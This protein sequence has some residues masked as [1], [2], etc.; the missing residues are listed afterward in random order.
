MAVS[1]PAPEPRRAGGSSS[2]KWRRGNRKVINGY[3]GEARAAL[4]AAA[5][6][7]D[8]GGDDSAAAAALGLVGAV[9]EM[10]PRMEA[11]LEL[12]ARA[13]LALRPYHDVA[14]MLRDYIPSCARSCAGDDT[15]TSSSS[16]SCSS[17]SGDLACA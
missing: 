5:A 3:I 16:A 6:R 14:E 15:A 9:L 4:A 7:D 12:R 8:D 10:S 11:A 1:S 17:G 13:L 2:S